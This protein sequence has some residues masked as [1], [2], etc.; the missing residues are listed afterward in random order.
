MT[1]VGVD[2]RQASLY[3][4]MFYGSRMSIANFYELTGIISGV[5]AKPAV[6]AAPIS[7]GYPRVP[8]ARG[9]MAS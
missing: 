7:P 1:V 3:M 2:N 4:K 6:S 5:R 8:G 9:L